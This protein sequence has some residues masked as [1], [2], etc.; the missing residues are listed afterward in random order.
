MGDTELLKEMN[1]KLDRLVIW[2][3]AHKEQHVLIQR[4]I[5]EVRIVLFG[6]NKK[7]G[8]VSTVEKLSF[9]KDENKTRRIFVRGFLMSVLR[10]VVAGIIMA[11][12]GWLLFL[13]KNN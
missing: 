1:G 7:Q 12:I 11:V 10:Y 9:C 3:A 8:L 6:K 2:Q 4:D 5:G 13:Y